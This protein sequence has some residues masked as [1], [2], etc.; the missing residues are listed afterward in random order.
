MAVPKSRSSKARKNKRRSA[1][2]TMKGPALV[3]CPRCGEYKVPHRACS[4]CG[5]YNGKEVL[6]GKAEAAK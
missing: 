4:E 5:Y 1:V 2:W 6:P 3:R